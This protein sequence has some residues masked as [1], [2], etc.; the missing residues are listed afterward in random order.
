VVMWEGRFTDVAP[1]RLDLSLAHLRRC[2]PGSVQAMVRSLEKRGQINPVTAARDGDRLILVDGFKRR[3]AAA[4]IGMEKLSAG[5]LP[6]YATAV[7]A[8]V[9]L[10]NRHGGFSL[11]E[12][13]LLLRELV[14][15]DGL[16]QVDVAVMMERHKSW[17]SRRLEI[18]RRLNPQIIE[19]IKVGLLPPGSARSLARLPECN[20]V[21]VGAAIQRDKL[22]GREIHRLIGLWCKA[23]SP[24]QRRF[25]VESSRK[26][27]ELSD[28]GSR[29]DPGLVPSHLLGFFKTIGSLERIARLLKH[30]STNGLGAMSP[31]S[32]TFLSQ[33]LAM[34]ETLCRDAI[35]GAYSALS[36]KEAANP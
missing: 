24:E 36:S 29:L 33:A 14:E 30:K 23:D 32:Q 27:L 8:L 34:A 18:V 26:A 20:Q 11:V 9:Y 25:I 15:K 12:E 35:A 7:K 10:L 1:S 4:L 22:K 5:V 2:P 28:P 16:L 21:D 6:H 17:V 19:D 13:C 3:Q 31:Q